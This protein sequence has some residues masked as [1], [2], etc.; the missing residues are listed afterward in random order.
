MTSLPRLLALFDQWDSLIEREEMISMSAGNAA[1][2]AV[3]SSMFAHFHDIREYLEQLHQIQT[4]EY[5][6]EI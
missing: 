5:D 3:S 2:D 4:E 6:D 1:A